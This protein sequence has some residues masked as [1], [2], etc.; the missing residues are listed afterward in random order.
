VRVQQAQT[1][2]P[3]R[4]VRIRKTLT[5]S[6]S[7]LLGFSSLII[8]G[9]VLLHLPIASREHV[10]QPWVDALF[11]A[12]SAVTTTGLVVVDTGSYYSLF[13][14]LVVLTL[15][16][17]GGLGYMA[18]IVF[19]M[20]L[21]RRSVGVRAGATLQES[22][23]GLARGDYRDFLRSMFLF[24]FLF[25]GVGTAILGFYW[26]DEFG[27]SRAFYLAAFHSVSAFCTAGFSLFADSFSAYRDSA[28]V[29]FTIAALTVPAGIGFVVLRDLLRYG[30]AMSRRSWPR[31]LLLHTKLAVAMSAFLAVF[32]TTTI[33]LAES[34]SFSRLAF[35][36]KIAAASFQS[37]SASTT[38]GF[39][40][41]DIGAMTATSLFA[42]IVLMFVGASPGG[43]AGGIKTTTLGT[44]LCTVRA[45][46]RGSVDAVAFGR[47]ISEDTVHRALTI[48]LLATV[49]IVLDTLVLTA[50]ENGSFLQI[51]FEVVSALG[52]VGLSAGITAGLSTAGKLILSATML[53]GRIGTLAIGF[54]LF[55]KPT[56][57]P[58]RYAE[59][60]VF[61]G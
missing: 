54:A 31:R 12:T 1:I 51:L 42:L 6:R 57:P 16:Q 48:G 10:A 60:K 7:L 14:Q 8:S 43:T 30:T 36:Q 20:L 4:S 22:V 34:D 29:N 38:T 26:M 55:A 15:F 59:E 13:G 5:P 58:F 45:L 35:G 46:L 27:A 28:L 3:V 18:F 25:E 11:T 49:V 47:R 33:L 32:G 56:P 53:T 21:A 9:T 24:T 40:S 50:T 41:V 2:P 23:G 52:T 19:A 39:N 61:I 17:I 37:L 44:V